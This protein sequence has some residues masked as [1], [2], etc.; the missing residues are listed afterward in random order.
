MCNVLF[1]GSPEK[2]WVIMVFKGAP[3]SR[4][5]KRILSF[6]GSLL[7]HFVKQHFYNEYTI[8]LLALFDQV[9]I[10]AVW[11]DKVMS[12]VNSCHTAH[13]VFSV[14]N[15]R[16]ITCL[17]TWQHNTHLYCTNTCHLIVHPVAMDHLVI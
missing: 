6:S 15:Q 7:N 16:E 13:A 3:K 9:C 17:E 2:G 11:S 10:H 4:R 14:V 8:F 5:E 12:W 1:R